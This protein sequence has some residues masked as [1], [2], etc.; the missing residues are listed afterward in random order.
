MTINT[1]IEYAK[2]DDLMLDPMNA[3]LGR[4]NTGR[5]VP[6]ATV[7]ELMKNWTLAWIP[8]KDEKPNKFSV[9]HG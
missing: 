3:R 7:M 2:L 5:T 1:T 4:S 8:M 6:Q 9:Q